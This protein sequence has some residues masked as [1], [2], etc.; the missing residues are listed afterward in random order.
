MKTRCLKI[1]PLLALFFIIS[2]CSKYDEGPI[3]NL[4]S[5]SKKLVGLWEVTS[6]K[7]NNVEY[8]VDYK[9]TLNA[10]FLIADYD[11]LYVSIVESSSS[12]SQLA[13]SALELED[14]N[15][16]MVLNFKAQQSLNSNIGYL[17]DLVPALFENNSWTIIMLTSNQFKIR[18]IKGKD[19]LIRFEKI[20]N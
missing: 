6:L 10:N 4:G 1:L 11:G 14:K 7:V 3:F 20:K 15:K 13:S 2:A 12:S 19:F 17:V 9:D 18:K 16:N 5:P 8:F